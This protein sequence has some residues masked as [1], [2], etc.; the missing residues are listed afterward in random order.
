MLSG[1]KPRWIVCEDGREYLLRC[2]RFL[3]GEFDFVP[4]GCLAEVEAALSNTKDPISGLLLDLDFKRTPLESLVD[5]T[6]RSNGATPQTQR[7]L[8]EVQ[9]I[10]ILKSLRSRQVSIPAILC[11]DLDD[12]SQAEFLCSTLAPLAISPS[13]D[14]VLGLANKMRQAGLAP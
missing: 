10:L 3:G 7:Q 4:A 2:E 11:A 12:V 1:V 8:A 6:G 14:G 9:G 5:E 13:S